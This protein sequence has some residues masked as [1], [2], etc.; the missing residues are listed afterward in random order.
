MPD[1]SFTDRERATLR[2][3]LLDWYEA[4]EQDEKYP[5]NFEEHFAQHK[6]LT[7]GELRDLLNLL[8]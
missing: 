8:K 4:N 6:P 5:E 2:A 3:A 1:L 7:L